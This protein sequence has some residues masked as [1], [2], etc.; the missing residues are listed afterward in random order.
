[1]FGPMHFVTGT[2]DADGWRRRRQIATRL[3]IEAAAWSLFTAQG[4]QATTVDQVAERAGISQ[5]TFFR[6]F[7][8]K[9]AVL[10]GEWRWQLDELARKIEKADLAMAPLAAVRTAVM[11][12]ADDMDHNRRAVRLRSSLT[13]S[14]TTVGNYYRQVIQ[15]AWEL[16]VAQAIA[17][18]LEVDIDVDPRPRTI[19]GAAIGALNAALAI[20]VAGG[21]TELLPDLTRRAFAVLRDTSNPA[22]A[23]AE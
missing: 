11:S 22:G 1:M 4:F 3:S 14:T 18:R 19:A 6:Y 15:P 21:C 12:L 20:W 10:F 13:S 5:R 23:T 2:P 9:E 16:A 17:T 7:D 8:S